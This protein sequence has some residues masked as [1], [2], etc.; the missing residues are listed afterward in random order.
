MVRVNNHTCPGLLRMNLSLYHEDSCTTN[1]PQLPSSREEARERGLDRFFTGVPCINGHIAARYVSTANCV[2]CQL[3]HARR[4]GGWKARPSKEQYLEIAREVVEKKWGGVLLSTEYVD[5]KSKLQVQCAQKHEF[6]I[7][8]DDLK[9]D[10]WCRECKRQNHSKRMAANFRTVEELRRF[11]RIEHEGDCLA[12]SPVSMN[13]RVRWKCKNPLHEPFSARLLNV[14]HQ[15]TWCPAC[16]AERRRLYP[17]NPQ[18]AR[19]TVENRVE[20][21]GGQIVAI[22]GDGSWKGLKTRLT[23]RCANG[24]PWDADASNLMHADSWCPDCPQIGE[25][26]ARAIFEATFSLTFPKCKPR[27][28]EEATGRKLELDGY[29]ERLQLAFEYQGPHHFTDEDVR[30]RDVLKRQA[31]L[32]HGVRLVEVE[33]AKKPFSPS[34]VVTNVGRALLEADIPNVPVMPLADLFRRELEE[35]QLFAKQMGGSLISTAYCGSDE[36]HEWHCG[37][38]DHPTWMAEP[39]RALKKGDWCPSCAGNCPLGL[40]GLRSWGE[41]VGLQLLDDEYH[42]TNYAYNW[43]C[44]EAQHTIQRRKGDVEQSLRKGYPACTACGPGISVNVL[45]RKKGADEFVM[46]MRPIIDGVKGEG[47]TSS[48]AIARRLNEMNVPTRCGSGTRWHA[49]SVKNLLHRLEGLSTAQ[50]GK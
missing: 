25:R 10:R 38:L 32:K 50:P 5:A 34:N 21:R 48:S 17:P 9:H 40:D 3:E 20:A 33:W 8:P 1:T 26:I 44:K 42:G 41:S 23:L 13:T 16:D 27:W 24:H 30:A 35:L 4:I 22:L 2:Q 45:A 31:C 36:P 6:G 29:C 19:K 28:L 7:T 15:G 46:Q 39:W 18:I 49:T 12:T 11:A 47:C 37:N 43:R 14:I